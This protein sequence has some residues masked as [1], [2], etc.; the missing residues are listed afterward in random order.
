[1]VTAGSCAYSKLQNVPLQSQ[2]IH[3]MFRQLPLFSEGTC[4]NH[5]PKL[6]VGTTILNNF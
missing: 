5:M 3:K 2:N 4:F 6:C 1:M